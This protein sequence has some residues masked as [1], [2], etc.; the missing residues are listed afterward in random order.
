MLSM[1]SVATALVLVASAADMAVPVL[2]A[3]ALVGAASTAARAATPDQ[4]VRRQVVRYG[5]LN[6]ATPSGKATFQGRLKDAV[7]AV[8]GPQ[9]DRRD[10]V[11]AADY[12]ACVTKASHD[13]MAALPDVRQ[14]A[15]R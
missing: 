5:D 3:P 11:E 2:I 15:S 9:A 8:C 6:L 4:T 12:K 7:E 14:Q 1:K 10:F 13:A